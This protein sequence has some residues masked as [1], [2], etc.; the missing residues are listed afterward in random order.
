MLLRRLLGTVALLLLPVLGAAAQQRSDVFT[1]SPVAVDATA[2]NATAARDQAVATGESRA[3]DLLMQRL[4]LASDRARLPKIGA[5]QLNE[6]VQGFEV[7]HER[8][9]GVRYL[10]DYTVHFRAEAVRQLLRQAGIGFAET[11]SKPLAVL[12]VLHQD[13]RST[14]WDDPNPWRD[15]WANAKPAPGLVPLVRPLGELE[16]VQAI[17]AEAASHGD[18][19][20]LQAISQRY[21]DA[22]VLVT[23]ATLRSD[24]EP[25]TVD[26]TSTRYS[27]GL[28]GTEQTWVTSAAANPGESDADMLGR[29][30]AE[31]LSQVEEA[32]KSANILDFRQSGTLLV[33]VPAAS[34]QDWVA[35]RD[36]L[37]G[38]PAVRGA[39]LLALDRE[40]A[41]V[42][43][44]YVGDPGQ[45]RLA[46]A[47]RDLELGGND[48]DWT[49]QR[50]SATAAPR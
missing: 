44:R 1:V 20:R 40:E 30:I 22:D 43:L 32:W 25:H 38:I 26:I 23:Q 29:A 45:L 47:Q 35:V 41:R 7:A 46:L 24:I 28:P 50:R 37:A 18:D 48:P 4:T 31:T 36:R 8:R 9:S 12:P 27:P 10:A 16:D 13:E 3:F 39:R 33:R 2:A 17:D 15:A 34:L 42:E 49:L 14:L 6:L 11:Q 19:E 5:A 21:R